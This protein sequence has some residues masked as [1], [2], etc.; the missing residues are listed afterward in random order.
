MRRLAAYLLC[1][2]GSV[3]VYYGVRFLATGI[4]VDFG[5]GAYVGFTLCAI[6]FWVYER[7]DH[8]TGRH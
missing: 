5:L 6:L 8:P 7:V 1:L 3:A 4:S 2:I